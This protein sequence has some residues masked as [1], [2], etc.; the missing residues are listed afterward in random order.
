[1]VNYLGHEIYEVELVQKRFT[2]KTEILRDLTYG[3]RLNHLSLL[4]LESQRYMMDLIVTYRLIHDLLDI[5][6]SDVVLR[7][8]TNNTRGD[9]LRLQ[10]QH[11]TLVTTAA[12]FQYR[13]AK[14]WNS[15]PLD[16]VK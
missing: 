1:M 5:S 14:L 4:S 10:Q 3:Q 6:L 11:T 16:I 8:C 15:L 13:A 2:K 7:I 12:L 9:G